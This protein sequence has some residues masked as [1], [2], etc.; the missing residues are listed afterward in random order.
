[1]ATFLEVGVNCLGVVAWLVEDASCFITE[2]ALNLEVDSF[3]EEACLVELG[4]CV[5]VVPSF[6]HLDLDHLD[7]GELMLYQVASLEVV[8]SKLLSTLELLY[9][10]VGLD[11]T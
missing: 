6:Q 3:V 2:E 7:L 8:A 10:L 5:Q 1:V 11:F 9:P 4:L